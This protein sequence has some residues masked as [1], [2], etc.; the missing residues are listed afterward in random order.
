MCKINIIRSLTGLIFFVFS[1][2]NIYSQDSWQSKWVTFEK[3]QLK[4]MPDEKGNVIPDFGRVGYHEGEIPSFVAGVEEVYP[5]EGDDHKRIQDAIDRV[6]MRPLNAQ[7]FRGAVVL[8]KGTYEVSKPLLINRSGIV[9]RGEDKDKTILVATAKKKYDLIEIRG[10]GSLVKEEKSKVRINQKY[11]PVGSKSLVLE[12]SKGL[13]VGDNIIVFRPGT[14]QWIKDLQMDRIHDNGKAKQWTPNEYNL[15]FERQIEKI[16]ED[17]IFIDYPI[18]MALDE[19]Y[20]GGFV[21][22]YNFNG[23]I[24]ECGLENLYLKSDFVNDT[25][26]KHG[27]TA[28]RLNSAE[29]CWVR[30]VTAKHFAYSCVSIDP[31]SR[32][33]SVL[34][35]NCLDPKSE[36]IGGR[37][38]AFNCNGQLNLFKGCFSTY[39]RHDFVTGARVC[40]PNVF[41]RCEA[42]NSQSDIGPH[43]RW[44]TGTLYDMNKTDGAIIVQD[45]GDY[46]TGHGWS[47]ANQV[48]WNCE[49][50][51][52][53]VQNPWKSAINYCIGSKGK[54]SAGRYPNRPDGEWEGFN[55]DKLN[56]E[57]LYD[58]QK[59]AS[60]AK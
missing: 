10:S 8:K 31:K 58:A 34:D 26:E 30:N 9:L 21:Y 35:C 60:S 7:G 41:T 29:H 27:W 54:K 39:G 33:I 43:H 28:I 20:G 40:G 2:S 52:I 51:T 11:V 55:Q 1:T 12:S 57:S 24:T 44:A 22:K 15:E 5:E 42:E 37:R 59:K 46:G 23:R 4:F 49:A 38:Y 18:V 32:N 13:N 19:N 6:A 45:R 17:T 3:G 14:K 47:G 48:F 50:K 25:D 36:I 53:T 16:S 56:P